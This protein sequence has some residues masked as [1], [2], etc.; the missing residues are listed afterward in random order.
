ML[1]L[2]KELEMTKRTTKHNAIIFTAFAAMCSAEP[3]MQVLVYVGDNNWRKY[4]D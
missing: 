3:Y 2:D 4:W 1:V